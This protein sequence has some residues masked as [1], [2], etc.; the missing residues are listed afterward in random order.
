MATATKK[1]KTKLTLSPAQHE[2]LVAFS[3]AN[4]RDWK[5]K[6]NTAWMNGRYRDY[7]LGHRLTADE[8]ENIYCC[9]QQVRNTFGPSWL[10]KFHVGNEKTHSVTKY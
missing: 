7:P 3:M 10:V 2:A 9:L 1:T 8:R 6:L 4:G 5:F